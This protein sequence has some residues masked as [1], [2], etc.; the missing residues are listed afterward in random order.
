MRK[1]LSRIRILTGRNLKE[2]IRDPLSMIFTILMPLFL[3]ILFYFIFH[4]MTDQFEM[5]Y[6]A[7]GIVVFSQAF[8][9]L[10]TGMLISVDRETSFLTR[11]Y[12][13]PARPYEFIFSYAIAVLPITIVQS[14]LFFSVGVIIE[15]SLFSAG[16]ICAIPLSLVTSLFFIAAGIL[17]GSLCS[18]KAIGG[19]ASIVIAGQSVLSGMWFPVE[20]LNPTIL[21][22]MNV[23]PFKNATTL[24]QNVVI[25]T[26]VNFD[27]FWKPLL[28]LAAY[29]IAVFAAA[30]LAF[31]A[32][33]KEQ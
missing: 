6:L 31:R 22:L 32:K 8:L 2:I 24:I 33:M 18:G 21:K 17:F 16:I 20:G 30:I 15:P 1:S 14:V 13:S 12:V 11:L 27:S 10:F 19:V 25:G 3:E 9:T 7:P 28:I 26:G 23:L 29:T 5:K 4:G